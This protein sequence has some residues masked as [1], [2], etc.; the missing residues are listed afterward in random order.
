MSALEKL[1]I[2]KDKKDKYHFKAKDNSHIDIDH[3]DKKLKFKL[4]KWDKEASVEVFL[5]MVEAD[6]HTF[7]DNKIEIEDSKK[8]IRVYPLDTRSTK[9]FYGDTT[10]DIQC[11]DGGLR[12]DVEY[13]EK[14]P[15][16]FYD[17]S[18]VC[19]NTRWSKQPFLTQE[20]IGRGVVCPINVE[21]SYAIYHVSK[22]NN[23]YMTGKMLH[24]YRPIAID[25]LGNKAWCDME[26]D[27]YIDPTSMRVTIPQQF[28]DEAI[29]PVTIDPDFGYTTIGTAGGSAI[30]DSA[31]CNRKGSA[32][33]MPAPG[34]TANYIKAYI[35]TAGVVVTDCRVFI[36]QKDS[37]AAGEHGQIAT[38]ENLLCGAAYH[39]EEF[40]LSGETLTEAVV[41]I[42]SV[43]GKP[44]GT[45]DDYNIKFD[46]NGAVDSYDENQTYGA[47][48]NPWVDTPDGV[49]RD[50]SIY[51][52]YSEPVEGGG[53][54]GAVVMGTKSLILDLLL[55]DV[56]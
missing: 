10:D 7:I 24:R 35:G 52:N 51:V 4:N 16:N 5:D 46:L 36:N 8:K 3:K 40:T 42:L 17:E 26:V 15:T 19:I 27:R 47:P 9:D 29:Y 50:Y 49:T 45:K 48:E 23:Q 1:K 28:L 12:Y 20:D 37:V 53:G 21:G 32:W 54:A 33:S 25:A 38:K 34:G 11:H 43:M 14:P 30:A 31:V 22:K 6:I 56:I 55:A 41:Y 2:F 39:W 44:H 18:L 13:F